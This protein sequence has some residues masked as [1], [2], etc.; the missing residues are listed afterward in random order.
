MQ[1]PSVTVTYPDGCA[2]TY[3]WPDADIYPRADLIAGSDKHTHDDPDDSA[4]SNAVGF[5]FLDALR[6]SKYASR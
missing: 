2:V 1:R 4:I 5:A 3:S 6:D